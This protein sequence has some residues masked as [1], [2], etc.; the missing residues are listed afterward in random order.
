MWKIVVKATGRAV[1]YYKRTAHL[2][3]ASVRG[4]WQG[5]ELQR[6]RNVNE[7]LVNRKLV[8][9]SRGNDRVS[10]VRG[11]STLSRAESNCHSIR[12]PSFTS[13]KL[14]ENVDKNNP[15][16]YTREVG[17]VSNAFWE[18]TLVTYFAS[19]L[20]DPILR[21]YVSYVV[22]WEFLHVDKLISIDNHR[23]GKRKWW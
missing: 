10:F 3:I 22:Y 4:D 1:W 21:K 2:R 7:S 19:Y 15:T 9:I 6:D 8:R 14:W 20:Y 11:A 18:K 5:L 23:T 13:L 16:S 17:P 12:L